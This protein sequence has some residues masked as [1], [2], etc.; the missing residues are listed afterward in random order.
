MW[1]CLA[2]DS[3]LLSVFAACAGRLMVSSV[4]AAITA[5]MP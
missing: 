3:M 5:G 1:V 2:A 4:S